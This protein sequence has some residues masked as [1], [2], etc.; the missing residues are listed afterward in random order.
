MQSQT[1]NAFML[2]LT[3]HVGVVLTLIG[4][5]FVVQQSRPP[6]VHVFELVAGPGNDLE[7]TEAPALGSPDGE[8]EV[9]VPT[10]PPHQARPKPSPES[11]IPVKT[12]ARTEPKISYKDFI[13]KHPPPAP[14]KPSTS[15]ASAA[16]KAPQPRTH[17][18]TDGV[19]G[20]SSRSHAGAGGQALTAA[21]HTAMEGYLSRLITA[22][23]Q[24]HQKPPGLS[25]LLKADV[26]YLVAPDGTISN[27]KIAESSG[28]AEFDQSCIE[29]FLRMGSAGPVPDGKAH[30]WITTFRMAEVE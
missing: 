9:K 5:A 25:D 15:G 18:I 12:P 10:L 7:A 8:I 11:M 16:A 26:E 29:A 21:Q 19:A 22:L 28:N 6:P 30:T 17:G 3:L 1:S 14:S 13:S 27:V 4:V 23:R 2:S 24:N 20:G